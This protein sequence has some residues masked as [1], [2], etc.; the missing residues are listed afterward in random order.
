MY[1]HKTNFN[2]FELARLCE[3]AIEDTFSDDKLRT[4]SVVYIKCREKKD[5][6]AKI[7]RDCCPRLLVPQPNVAELLRTGQE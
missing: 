2:S 6:V 3:E 5:I 1:Y 4:R 7:I